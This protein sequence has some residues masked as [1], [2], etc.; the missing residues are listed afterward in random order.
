[1]AVTFDKV[2]FHFDKNLDD[3]EKNRVKD[4][5]KN[6]LEDGEI[7]C[8]KC[9]HAKALVYVDDKLHVNEEELKKN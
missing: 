5:V 2:K 6:A 1:M 7:E 3:T 4:V 9:D 8:A